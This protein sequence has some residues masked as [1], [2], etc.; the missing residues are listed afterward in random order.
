VNLVLLLGLPTGAQLV[1]K[2]LV[3]IAGLALYRYLRGL[4]A[5]RDTEPRGRAGFAGAAAQ[6]PGSGGR[7]DLDS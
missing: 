4:G 2:A 6:L 7:G 3:I 5:A 1:A